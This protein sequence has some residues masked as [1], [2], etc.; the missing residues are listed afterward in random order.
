MIGMYIG[1]VCCVS[2]DGWVDGDWEI[3]INGNRWG[4]AGVGEI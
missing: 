3:W 4:L 2:K 1:E